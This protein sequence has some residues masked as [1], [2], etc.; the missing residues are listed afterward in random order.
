M[1]ESESKEDSGNVKKTLLYS[2]T[3][4]NDTE[5]TFIGNSSQW[6]ETSSNLNWRIFGDIFGNSSAKRRNIKTPIDTRS[7]I[8]NENCILMSGNNDHLRDKNV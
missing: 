7:Q 2:N 6:E 1:I 4:I 8:V 3:G 5:T